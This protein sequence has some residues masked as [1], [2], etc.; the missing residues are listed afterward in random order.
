MTNWDDFAEKI[1]DYLTAAIPNICVWPSH[2]MAREFCD[3]FVVEKF[4]DDIPTGPE[5]GFDACR[6]HPHITSDISSDVYEEVREGFRYD[7]QY[8]KEE[9]EAEIE[10]F[11]SEELWVPL[12]LLKEG[13]LSEDDKKDINL[14][15]AELEK[16]LENEGSFFHIEPYVTSL[17]GKEVV[18]EG[19]EGDWALNEDLF[20]AR[21]LDENPNLKE[22]ISFEWWDDELREFIQ[23]EI[24]MLKEAVTAGWWFFGLD[25]WE[26]YVRY[27]IRHSGIDNSAESA[28]DGKSPSEFMRLYKESQEGERDDLESQIHELKKK[29]EDL[30]TEIDFAPTECIICGSPL[31]SSGIGN[32]EMLIEESLE[33]FLITYFSHLVVIHRE[34]ATLPEDPFNPSELPDLNITWKAS[35]DMPSFRELW[36]KKEGKESSTSHINDEVKGWLKTIDDEKLSSWL[37][38]WAGEFGELGIAPRPRTE[39]ELELFRDQEELPPL[40]GATYLNVIAERM[41]IDFQRVGWKGLPTEGSMEKTLKADLIDKAKSMGLDHNGKK[42]ELVKRILESMNPDELLKLPYVPEEYFERL[43][44]EIGRVTEK[45]KESYLYSS[46]IGFLGEIMVESTDQGISIPGTKDPIGLKIKDPGTIDRDFFLRCWFKSVKEIDREKPYAGPL[47]NRPD[48]GGLREFEHFLDYLN[49]WGTAF[50]FGFF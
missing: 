3:T 39:H 5:G 50:L 24:D 45:G 35:L 36:H 21:F 13:S 10:Y 15:I 2:R 18:L 6:F 34:K 23:R 37:S 47:S 25:D 48:K 14:Y 40:E 33:K 38:R 30:P 32:F 9:I 20:P 46:I 44:G 16:V 19:E 26:G 49:C 27:E 1:T 11:R 7:I 4:G 17:G 42:E 41:F 22:S 28:I 43:D 29:I 8:E 12:H 31:D